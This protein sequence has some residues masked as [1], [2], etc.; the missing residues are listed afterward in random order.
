MT[1]GAFARAL[2]GFEVV[3]ADVPPGRWSA[4]SPCANW[5]AADVAGHMIGAPRETEK[6]ARGRHEE[7]EQPEHPGPAIGDHPLAA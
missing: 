7:T 1:L 6:L 2:D 3:L 4:P 5:S